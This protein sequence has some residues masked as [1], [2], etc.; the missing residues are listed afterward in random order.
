M[1]QQM[2]GAACGIAMEGGIAVTYSIANFPTLRCLEQIRNDVCY[3]NANVKI[4]NIGG[5]VSY[6]ALGISHHSTE[7]IAI[8]RALPNMVVVVPCDNK[9]AEAATYAA[10]EYEGPLFYRCGYK[11]EKD[12]HHGDVA[13]LNFQL[14][15]AITVEEGTDC[16]VIFC[17]PIGFEAQKAV[18]AARAKGIN[19]RL[20]SMHTIKPID[21]EAIVKAAKETGKIITVE[22]HN[23]SGGLGSAVAEVLAD[24]G[25][26]VKMKRMAL[27]DV[28]VH[29][30]GSQQWL[31]EQYGLTAPFIEKEIENICK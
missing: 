2:T 20:I 19:C 22:E 7:D 28:Y 12:I 27:P 14:G 11:N 13:S 18:E 16:T 23:M 3:H 24:E 30:V 5:G 29:E 1:E 9:E 17:G 15:K 10:F 26:C 6:G 4:V 21:R 8:M 31:R 25:C